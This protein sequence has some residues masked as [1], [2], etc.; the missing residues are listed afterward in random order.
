MEVKTLCVF[1]LY[2][3]DYFSL[4]DG[5]EGRLSKYFYDHNLFEKKFLETFESSVD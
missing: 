5:K 2:P 3:E 4:E 1:I